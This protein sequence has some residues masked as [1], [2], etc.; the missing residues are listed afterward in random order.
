MSALQCDHRDNMI[1]AD[2]RSRHSPRCSKLRHKH[3][4][5]TAGTTYC[6]K[7]QDELATQH[8]RGSDPW[9]STSGATSTWEA[10]PCVW[11]RA[12]GP[13]EVAVLRI[14]ALRELTEESARKEVKHNSPP[15]DGVSTDSACALVGSRG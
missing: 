4:T 7:T 15:R 1:T 9:G 8:T 14:G 10:G 5:H 2:L 11:H 3:A 12:L 13:S 6:C